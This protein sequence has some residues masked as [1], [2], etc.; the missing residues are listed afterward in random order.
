MEVLIQARP[1]ILATFFLALVTLVIG[2]FIDTKTLF[3]TGGI[4]AH[5]AL[6]LFI[7]TE[8]FG[9]VASKRSRFSRGVARVALVMSGFVVLGIIASIL[10]RVFSS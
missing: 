10:G 8:S 9:S 1:Y 4:L 3:K 2:L 6:F 5:V 7:L